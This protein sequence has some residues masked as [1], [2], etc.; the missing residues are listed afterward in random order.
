[1]V[2]PSVI[3]DIHLADEGMQRIRWVEKF[4]PALNTLS[5]TCFNPDTFKGKTIV[6]SIHLE[7]KT[8]YLAITLKK[9]GANVIATGS[10]PLSTQDPIAAALVSQGITVYATHGCTDKEYMDYLNMALDHK[11]HLIIDDGGDLV[12]LLHTTRK[13]ALENLIGG[14]EETTTGVYRLRQLANENKL[15]FPMLAVNNSQCKFLFD[16][17][18]GTGQSVWDGIIRSTNLTV[19]GKTVVV[20]GYGWCGKGVAMRAKGLGAHVIVTEVDPIK[21]IEA[22]FDCFDVKPMVEA[23][24]YGDYFV[25]VTGDIH[26]INKDAF[27]A[28]KDGAICANA[29]HFDVEVNKEDLKEISVSHFE[30]RKN[31]EGYVL[32]DGRT[33]YLMAE[34]RLVNLAAGDGHPAEIMDLSF[35]MQALAADYICRHEKELKPGLY[36]LPHELD[37][38]VAQIKLS[39]MGYSID[40]LTE[41]QKAYLGLK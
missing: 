23:A 30:A 4:M 11:P 13:D 32:P 25:T 35:A 40:S 5:K 24:P 8:A 1:M 41:E 37:V 19:T 22:V 17:R 9:A 7:A 38:K 18:Y 6:I 16:N 39:S 10:N 28:M 3:R 15:L 33:I 12:H 20:A 26:V 36:V 27:L 14:S 34:G 31:I 2:K 29:G 21:A